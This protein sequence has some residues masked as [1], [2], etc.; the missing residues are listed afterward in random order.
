MTGDVIRV[1]RLPIE[2][3]QTIYQGFC[4]VR[5]YR[6]AVT[7]SLEVGK[8]VDTLGLEGSMLVR[9]ATWLSTIRHDHL[10][11]VHSVAVVEGYEPP[12]NVI[13]MLMPYY[14]RGSVADA[15]AT[16]KRF[17]VAESRDHVLAAL[18]GVGQLHEVEHV[19]HRD[20]KSP[21]VLLT[22]DARLARVGDLGVATSMDEDGSAE[23]YAN[24]QL[25]SPPEAFTTHR[26][27]RRSDLYAV[28][29]LLQ[30]MVNGPLPWASYDRLAMTRRLA[31]GLRAPLDRD[32]KLGPHVPPRMRRLITKALAVS[33]T[34]RPASATIMADMLANVPLVDWVMV[35]GEPGVAHAWEGRSS[36]RQDRSYRIEATSKQRGGWKLTGMHRVNGWRRVVSDQMVPD[37]EDR[38]AREFF[39][40]IVAIATR[41]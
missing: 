16:G 32:L 29:L 37:L 17:S 4:E 9:E 40:Q 8:R 2:A 34:Q 24:A 23:A 14:E 3:L 22:G 19:L 21:N 31:R 28:G 5:L 27:D 6:N 35:R 41:R 36:T 1:L 26:V 38:S 11:P 30:E 10:V 18:R 7:G 25:Y 12:L 13:E 33:P 39:D 15:F 20:I